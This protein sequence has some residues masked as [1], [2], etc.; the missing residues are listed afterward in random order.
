MICVCPLSLETLAQLTL[1]WAYAC[2]KLNHCFKTLLLQSETLKQ[3][4]VTSTETLHTSKTEV[5]TV[6]STVQSLEIEL[7]SLLAMVSMCKL[8]KQQQQSNQLVFTLKTQFL[9]QIINR[10][11]LHLND[12]P[13]QK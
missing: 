12:K 11:L 3:E 5:N 9:S 13:I 8:V 10:H 6:K 7:Q 4:V 1:C 2:I